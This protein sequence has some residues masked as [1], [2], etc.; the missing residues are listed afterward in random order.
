MVPGDMTALVNSVVISH[1]LRKPCRAE[2]TVCSPP[3]SASGAQWELSLTNSTGRFKSLVGT[4][5]FEARNSS[6]S[7]VSLS[8][9]EL[10]PVELRGLSRLSKGSRTFPGGL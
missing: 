1:P 2:V 3:P 8:F 5:G 6:L 10:M 4:V 9:N 7:C